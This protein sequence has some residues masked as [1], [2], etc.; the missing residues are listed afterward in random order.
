[1][2][3]MRFNKFPSVIFRVKTYFCFS[4]PVAHGAEMLS[5]DMLFVR[6]FYIQMYLLIVH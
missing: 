1:M 5:E 3:A 6:L 4:S 2:N